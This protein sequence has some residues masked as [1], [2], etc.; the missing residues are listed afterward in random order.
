VLG[1]LSRDS[2]DVRRLPCEHITVVLQ[3][4]DEHAFLFVVEARTDDCSLAF[5]RESKFDPFS[6]F[7]RPHRGYGQTFIRRDC[8]VFIHQLDIDLCGMGYRGPDSESHL[9][10]TLKAFRGALEVS[11]HGDD[12]LRSWHFEYHILVVRNGHE[13]C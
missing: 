12:P 3:E 5:I 9:N 1:Q 8:E 13:F 2:Q 7:S 4:L 10:G 6:F 11:V